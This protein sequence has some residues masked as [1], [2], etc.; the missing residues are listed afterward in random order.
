MLK[1]E[2]MFTIFDAS[3]SALSFQRVVVNQSKIQL[4]IV[5]KMVEGETLS[6]F[7]ARKSKVC[8]GILG[9]TDLST[10]KPDQE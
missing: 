4:T 5:G 2:R 8:F 6:I 3:V 10:E 7:C 9:A 1:H